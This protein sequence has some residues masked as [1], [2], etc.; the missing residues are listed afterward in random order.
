[1]TVLA[2]AASLSRNQQ[3]L[4]PS[5]R[6]ARAECVLAPGPN[7]LVLFVLSRNG[8]S[9]NTSNVSLLP[10]L[11]VEMLRFSFSCVHVVDRRLFRASGEVTR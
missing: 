11:R 10:R 2:S 3:Q 4:G 7:G 9:G 6:D 5:G 8:A 1:V